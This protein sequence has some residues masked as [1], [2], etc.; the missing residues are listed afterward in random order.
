ML[1]SA[2]SIDRPDI[3]FRVASLMKCHVNISPPTYTCKVRPTTACCTVQ[4][5]WNHVHLAMRWKGNSHLIS[6]YCCWRYWSG[7]NRGSCGSLYVMC[8]QWLCYCQ[9]LHR[10]LPLRPSPYDGQFRP[11]INVT[12]ER[13]LTWHCGTAKFLICGGYCVQIHHNERDRNF[14]L[15]VTGS[16]D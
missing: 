8:K 2:R 5:R 6:G 7:G 3:N 1:F 11:P 10:W 15:W 13:N 4:M 9:I 16:Y 12:H 14:V